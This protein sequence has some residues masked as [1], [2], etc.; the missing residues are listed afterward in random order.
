MPFSV[1]TSAFCS[2]LKLS[3]S[4][5]D[6][7]CPTIDLS[8]LSA[9]LDTGVPTSPEAEVPHSPVSSSARPTQRNITLSQRVPQLPSQPISSSKTFTHSPI[10]STT[11]GNGVA[12]FCFVLPGQLL[13]IEAPRFAAIAP[14]I[15]VVDLCSYLI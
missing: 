7:V 6:H 10:S 15:F 9:P 1:H 11:K 13:Q 5:V 4:V 12:D 3:R 14:P 2:L 8:N